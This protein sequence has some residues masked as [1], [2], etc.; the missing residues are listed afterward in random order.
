M[1]LNKEERMAAFLHILRSLSRF[2]LVWIVLKHQ[3]VGLLLQFSLLNMHPLKQ[4]TPADFYTEAERAPGWLNL[5]TSSLPSQGFSIC[6]VP[7]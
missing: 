3:V 5:A 2:C 4:K 7:S 6:E 1:T